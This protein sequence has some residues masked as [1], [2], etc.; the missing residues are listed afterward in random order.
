M[1]DIRF[2][3]VTREIVMQNNDF[4]LQPNPSVQNGG[5]AQ[6][7]RVAHIRTP[8]FGIGVEEFMN[9]D[10]TR[11]AYEMN[12]WKVMVSNDGATIARWSAVPIAG[13][14]VAV[15]TEISYI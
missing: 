1:N 13:N 5:I 14:D 4:A 11:V 7:S 2:D 3:I 8:M 10:M 6:Y 9:A 12:R 15:Q